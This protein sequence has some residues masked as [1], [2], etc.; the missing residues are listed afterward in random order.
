M[1]ILIKTGDADEMRKKVGVG[2]R[3]KEKGRH[4]ILDEYI[5]YDDIYIG[6]FR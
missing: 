6:I 2:K 3:E 5:I 4:T 1:D